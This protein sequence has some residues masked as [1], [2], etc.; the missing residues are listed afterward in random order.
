MNRAGDVKLRPMWRVDSVSAC[1][2]CSATGRCGEA[3][4]P[5]GVDSGS[6]MRGDQVGYA[7]SPG[8][9]AVVC[10]R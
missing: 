4:A 10:R 9:M 8:M 7:K 6:A 1:A 5:R 3:A 2:G